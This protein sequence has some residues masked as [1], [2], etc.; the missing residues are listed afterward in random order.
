MFCLMQYDSMSSSV[1]F[2]TSWAQDPDLRTCSD[3]FRFFMTP[4]GSFSLLGSDQ[5]CIIGMCLAWTEKNFDCENGI[6]CY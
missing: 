2:V 5:L 3:S 1:R 6:A 4:N